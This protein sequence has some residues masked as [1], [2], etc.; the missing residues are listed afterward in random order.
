MGCKRTLL[1]EM[2][3][4][5]YL[6]III[7]ILLYIAINELMGRKTIFN[8]SVKVATLYFLLKYAKPRRQLELQRLSSRL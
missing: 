5:V 8:Q 4:S 2:E 1:L 7:I 3:V 6:I